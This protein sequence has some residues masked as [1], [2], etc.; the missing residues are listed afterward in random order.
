MW[1][2]TASSY[3]KVSK[4]CAYVQSSHGVSTGYCCCG[5]RSSLVIS[6]IGNIWI[7]LFVPHFQL[8]LQ[9][10]IWFC[11]DLRFCLDFFLGDIPDVYS[12]NVTN[13]IIFRIQQGKTAADFQDSWKIYYLAVACA[14]FVFYIFNCVFLFYPYR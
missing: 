2:T 14:S 6:E 1:L 10:L 12:H 13:L 3:I 11:V 5:H 7:I 9:T 4:I 8:F